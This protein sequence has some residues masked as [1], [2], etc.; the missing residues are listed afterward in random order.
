VASRKVNVNE[1]NILEFQYAWAGLSI[2]RNEDLIPYNATNPQ[3]IYRS[4]LVKF[5]NK[6]V[7]ILNNDYIFDI[8]ELMT[9]PTVQHSLGEL[10]ANFFAVFFA[11]DELDQQLIKLSATW[12]YPI[13]QSESIQTNPLVL[14]AAIQLPILLAPPFNFAIPA[15]FTIPAGGCSATVSPTDSFVCKLSAAIKTWYE[16]NNPTTTNAWIQLDVSVFSS[17]TEVKLPLIEL[18]NIILFYSDIN[19]LT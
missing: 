15:D 6:L 18:K 7:P 14:P 5:S 13:L 10:L 8:A 4:P 16:Q 12:N 2:I 17:L 11:K 3:F 9:V 1:L 19:D